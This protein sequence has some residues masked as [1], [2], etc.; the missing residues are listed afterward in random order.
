MDVSIPNADTLNSKAYRLSDGESEIVFI[1]MRNV[2]IKITNNDIFTSSDQSTQEYIR[3]TL[4]NFIRW[5]VKKCSIRGACFRMPIF[6]YIED[7]ASP[8]LYTTNSKLAFIAITSDYV[9]FNFSCNGILTQ[10]WEP[11]RIEFIIPY[12][13]PSDF[14]LYRIMDDEA[15]D[16]LEE[17]FEE[18]REETLDRLYGEH[19]NH[20]LRFSPLPPIPRTNENTEC[21]LCCSRS[22]YVCSKCNEPLCCSC[23]NHLKKSTNACPACRDTPIILR[24]IEG[25]NII[26]KS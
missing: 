2:E 19:Q 13:Q 18:N 20:T 5:F 23:I 1:I 8:L 22:D 9:N 24:Q 7:N 3:F 10:Y 15:G 26:D 11:L 6:N 14:I 17:T 25:G 12:T 4:L 21:Q 16:I